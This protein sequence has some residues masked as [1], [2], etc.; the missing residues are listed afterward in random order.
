MKSIHVEEVA[1]LETQT[2]KAEEKIGANTL[3]E[4]NNR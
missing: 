2:E 1:E 3:F 4:G